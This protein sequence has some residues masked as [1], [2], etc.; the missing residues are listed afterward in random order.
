MAAAEQQQA[1]AK[2][3]LA[4]LAHMFNAFLEQRPPLLCNACQGST[5]AAAGDVESFARVSNLFVSNPIYAHAKAG[6]CHVA[7]ADVGSPGR[8][9][10]LRQVSCFG[11]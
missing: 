10:Q 4:Q 3:V 1:F 8:K 11:C 2:V 6:R 7:G 5:A 9:L